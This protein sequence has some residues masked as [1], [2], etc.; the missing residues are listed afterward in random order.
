MKFKKNEKTKTFQQFSNQETL[1]NSEDD[2]V[3]PIYF[4]HFPTPETH[5]LVPIRSVVL[6]A[7][8]VMMVYDPSLVFQYFR[9]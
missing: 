4:T 9:I 3:D 1:G 8:T 2:D 6:A 7:R 5:F